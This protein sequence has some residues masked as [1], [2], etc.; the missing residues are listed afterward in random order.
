MLKRNVERIE[1]CHTCSRELRWAIVGQC[2]GSVG[3]HRSMVLLG[4]LSFIVLIPFLS[5]FLNNLFAS[6]I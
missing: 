1:H 5:N 3:L 4:L 2:C 6:F